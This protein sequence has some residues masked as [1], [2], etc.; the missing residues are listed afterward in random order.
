M[1]RWFLLMAS[2]VLQIILGGIYAWSVFVPALDK[3]YNIN[4]SKSSLVFGITIL[5]FTINM[6]F[7]GRVLANKGPRFTAMI[8]ALLYSTGYLVASFSNGNYFIILIGIGI[9]TGAG[10]GFGYVCPLT[11]CIK[12]F[13]KKKGLI[14]GLAVA[15]FGGGAIILTQFVSILQNDGLGPLMIFRY[16]AIL[17]GIP[18]IAAALA[19]TNP[20]DYKSEENENEKII[21]LLKNKVIIAM[22]IGM[23][24]G[25]FGGLMVVSNIKQIGLANNL[26]EHYAEL[27]ISLFAVGNALGRIVWGTVFDKFGKTTIPISLIMLGGSALIMLSRS[28]LLFNFGAL[29]IGLAFGGCFVLYFLR[30]V[31]RFGDK[32]GQLYPYVFLAYGISAVLGPALGGSIYDITGTYR[33]AIYGLLFITLLGA[34]GVYYIEIRSRE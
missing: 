22:I 33:L 18:A 15:G 30:I 24:S 17:T 2:I 29:S 27:S 13:P 7:A 31:E 9:I 8:G 19:L 10:I 11:T 34:I 14:T 32:A 23:F 12:W 28:H 5:V 20:P 25:T 4:A 16:I 26:A 6:I 1:K 21:Y 3:F